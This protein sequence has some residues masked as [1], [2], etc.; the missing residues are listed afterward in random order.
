ML[1]VFVFYICYKETAIQTALNI[2]FSNLRIYEYLLVP[3]T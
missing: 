3:V 1:F 2:L